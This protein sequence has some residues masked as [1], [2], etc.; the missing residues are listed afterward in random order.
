[1]AESRSEERTKRRRLYYSLRELHRRA[2]QLCGRIGQVDSVLDI[3]TDLVR[4]V[5]RL[6]ADT[7][8]IER[9][10]ETSR[11]QLDR[12]VQQ[13]ESA[14]EQT[15]LVADTCGRLESALNSAARIVRPG[16]LPWQVAAGVAGSGAAV[17]VL[18][19]AVFALTGTVTVEVHNRGCGNL[20]LPSSIAAFVPGVS[21]PDAIEQG[22]E[23]SFVTA[24][25][26][27]VG[28][29]TLAPGEVEGTIVNLRVFGTTIPVSVGSLD[30]QRS[31]WDG[32]PLEQLFGGP[33]SLV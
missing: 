27:L 10:P 20:P 23:P 15:S 14:G 2:E 4:D 26:L 18:A 21:L 19:A 13:L 11:A 31:S 16:L 9:L 30:L 17:V 24:P 12:A 1:M 7:Q 29:V 25:R 3:V 6:L 28:S 33:I 32:I 22:P 8:A 5:R